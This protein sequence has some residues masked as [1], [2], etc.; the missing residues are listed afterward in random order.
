M[1]NEKATTV[2]IK[3]DKKKEKKKRHLR[4]SLN[5]THLIVLSKV[6]H[7]TTRI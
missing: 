7:I 6:F 1:S 2:H 4:M 3:A 5:N